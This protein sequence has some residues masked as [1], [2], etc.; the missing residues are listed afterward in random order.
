MQETLQARPEA[1]RMIT[2]TVILDKVRV[3]ILARCKIL[4]RKR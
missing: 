1:V 3:E 4:R 2:V